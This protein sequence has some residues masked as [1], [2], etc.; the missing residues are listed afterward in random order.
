MTKL[1]E[2]DSIKS[3]SSPI[4]EKYCVHI[5]NE[6]SETTLNKKFDN[7]IQNFQIKFLVHEL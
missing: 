7:L 6:S 1:L 3:R 2:I 4:I 5:Y